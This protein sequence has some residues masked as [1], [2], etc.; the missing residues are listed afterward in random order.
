MH[1]RVHVMRLI[2]LS[3]LVLLF[4]TVSVPFLVVFI[5]K[6]R[7]SL[8][9]H[10]ELGVRHWFEILKWVLGVPLKLLRVSLLSEIVDLLLLTSFYTIVFVIIIFKI[11]ILIILPVLSFTRLFFVVLS[12]F[13][14]EGHILAHLFLSSIILRLRFSRNKRNLVSQILRFV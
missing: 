14:I 5:V 13:G 4:T 11:L 10:S 2:L 3:P 1:V 9:S 12:I 8:L 6:L 7:I